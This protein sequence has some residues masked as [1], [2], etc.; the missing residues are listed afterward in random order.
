MDGRVRGV[1]RVALV[2]I[3]PEADPESTSEDDGSGIR[4]EVLLHGVFDRLALLCWLVL[5]EEPTSPGVVAIIQSLLLRTC[6]LTS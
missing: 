2:V 6:E 4:P 1:A 5:P 3:E